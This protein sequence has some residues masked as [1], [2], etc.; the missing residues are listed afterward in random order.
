MRALLDCR[1]A[2]WTGVGRYTR[3]IARALA[4]SGRLEV[5][6]VIAIGDTPPAEGAEAIPASANPLSPAGAME[7]ARIAARVRPD[8]THCLHFPTPLPARHPLVVTLHDLS[9]LFVPGV[10]PS[11]ARRLAY[12]WW[13]RRALDAADRVIAPS[14]NTS[15]DLAMFRPPAAKRIRVVLEAADD[16][17]MGPVGPMPLR[18]ARLAEQPYVLS[19]GNPKPHKDLPTLLRA[20][21]ALAESRSDLLLVLVGGDEGLDDLV[22][23]ALPPEVAHRVAIT[24]GVT[25]AEL[26]ALYADAAVFAFPSRYEGFG[27]PPLEAMALGAPVVCAD[28]SSLPEVVGDAAL[29]FPPGDDVALRHA[30]ELVLDESAVR[31]DLVHRGRRRAGAFSWKDTAEETLAVYEEAIPR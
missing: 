23:E 3:G 31:T 6:Q 20:Y 14:V 8:V 22:A 27:L 18:L 29:M 25:D 28:S 7:L 30:I 9:P 26:R 19:F 15:E 24:G 4:A 21:R 11:L 12:A 1:M 16:F 17:S 5:V 10:M 2:T 13:N